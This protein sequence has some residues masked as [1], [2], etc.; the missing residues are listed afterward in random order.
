MEIQGTV[1][2]SLVSKANS[3][4]ITRTGLVIKSQKAIEFTHSAI[5]QLRSIYK[6]KPIENNVGLELTI[7]YDSRR[8]DLS[9]ELFFDCLEKAGVLKND[10]Q[11]HEYFC[12]KE[13]DKTKPRVEFVLYELE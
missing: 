9:P 12:R 7:F 3:R 1:Y 4:R 2:G 5:L 11:I 10:R 8:P 13:L 6:K